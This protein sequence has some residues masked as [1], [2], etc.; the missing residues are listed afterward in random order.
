MLGD[1]TVHYR[2]LAASG[3]HGHASLSEP[4]EP[5]IV[6]MAGLESSFR[7]L[8]KWLA[9]LR[10]PTLFIMLASLFAIDFFVPD[11]FPLVDELLLGILTLLAARWKN[12]SVT[13]TT[14]PPVQPKP[15]TKNVTPTN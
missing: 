11:P 13:S 15:P 4:F 14:E 6:V 10:S 7:S 2:L 5:I 8:F 3:F 12:R 1:H 9:E